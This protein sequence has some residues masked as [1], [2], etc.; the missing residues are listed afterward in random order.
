M[1]EFTATLCNQMFN[2]GLELGKLN[3]KVNNFHTC[4]NSWL[5]YP[6]PLSQDCHACRHDLEKYVKM[7][8]LEIPYK[9][10]G[11]DA[12]I[13]SIEDHHF[14]TIRRRNAEIDMAANI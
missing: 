8:H 5:R 4:E 11:W 9:L 3:E 12:I 7:L 13:E 6:W 2:I 14:V 10:F 1:S